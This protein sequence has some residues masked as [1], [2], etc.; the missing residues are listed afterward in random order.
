MR[1]RILKKI[2]KYALQVFMIF[3]VTLL[4]F[5]GLSSI[6]QDCSI[7][8]WPPVILT[9]VFSFMDFI[10]RVSY[11][12]L[13]CHTLSL[14]LAFFKNSITIS[15]ETSMAHHCLFFE[16]NTSSTVS[17]MCHSFAHISHYTSS[18]PI[19]VEYCTHCN[20]RSYQWLLWYAWYATCTSGSK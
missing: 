3:F 15:L 11:T 17:T 6:V 1:F 16:S 2:W 9:A 12:L 5:P 8:N 10:S 14:P 19:L 13:I 18:L 7:T 4:I 20:G